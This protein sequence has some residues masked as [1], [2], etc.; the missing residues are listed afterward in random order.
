MEVPQ[1]DLVRIVVKAQPSRSRNPIWLAP[2]K[3][4]VQM[5]IRPAERN[6]QGVV[7]PGDGAVAAHEQ[8]TPN[9]G[10]NV[11]YPDAQLIHLYCLIRA[12]HALPLL[13]SSLSRVYRR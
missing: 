9:L 12:A 5:L 11:A 8:A 7:K 4:A 2:N 6:L 3:E 10:T 1:L 13:K